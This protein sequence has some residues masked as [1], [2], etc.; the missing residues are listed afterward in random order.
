MRIEKCLSAETHV[1][2]PETLEVALV[3][4]LVAVRAWPGAGI[5]VFGLTLQPSCSE[6][7]VVE[8][9]ASACANGLDD[10]RDGASDCQDVDC[11]ESGVCETTQATCANGV[12][13]DKNG[14]TDCEEAACVSG[15]FCTPFPSECNIVPQEGCPQGMGCYP[16]DDGTR[17]CRLAGLGTAGSPCDDNASPA[18]P[19]A[20]AAGQVCVSGL[21]N[22]I[23]MHDG[24]CP[25]ETICLGGTPSNM[26]FGICSLPCAPIPVRPACP[27]GWNCFS[28]HVMSL[29]YDPSIVE[30]LVGGGAT[31][32]CLDTLVPF[33]EGTA[34][35]GD[36]CDESP[37]NTALDRVCP[38]PFACAP[39]GTGE[40]RCRTLCALGP[41][42][43]T[44]LQACQSGQDCVPLIAADPRPLSTWGGPLVLG[45]CLDR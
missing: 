9:D 45:V 27:E 36:P 25:R 26:P 14:R 29:G 22:P 35:E 34:Q 15:G 39:D 21:C 2:T 32:F 19:S 12:D 1:L 33:L 23:C 4:G 8:A 37:N 18:E 11:N 31:W 10:D 40:F 6:P 16:F 41:P 44:E 24:H 20:C 7:R 38:S 5:V 30:V 28:G 43:A 13:D 42:N 3:S 17:E